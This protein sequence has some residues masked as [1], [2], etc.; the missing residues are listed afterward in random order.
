MN[1]GCFAKG[2]EIAQYRLV[3]PLFPNKHMAKYSGTFDY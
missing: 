2:R 3:I 1:I